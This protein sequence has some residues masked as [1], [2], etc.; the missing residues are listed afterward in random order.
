MKTTLNG[1]P[2]YI[3]GF[4]GTLVFR[5]ITP[6]LGL[7]NFSPLMATEFAGAKAYG[8]ALAGLYGFLSIV[9]LDVI[10]GKVGLWTL[11]TALTYGAV[12]VWAAYFFSGR[13]ATRKNFVVASIVGTLFFDL[14]TGICM[15]PILFGQSFTNAFVGQVP[16]T[17]HH[18]AGTLFFALVLA[19]WFY[20]KIMENPKW[21]FSHILRLA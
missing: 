17:I 18:L 21:E 13:S 15:G 5:L 20:E 4:I 8:P 9:M 2:K 19:P 6:I 10:V 12:G 7:A 1:L 11:V 3:A 14:V 16:F